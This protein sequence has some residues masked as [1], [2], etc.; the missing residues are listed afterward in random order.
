MG[1]TRNTPKLA[2]ASIGIGLA[3]LFQNMT[4]I[5]F[6]LLN[7]PAVDEG[8]RSEQAREL[9]GAYYSESPASKAEGASHLNYLLYKEI[10]ASLAPQWKQ[11]ALELTQ[12]L[13]AESREQ[14]FDPIFVLAVIQTES[15]FNPNA[16]GTAG[17]IG[18]MQ[19]LPQTGKW[20]AR[21]YRL[22]WAGDRTLHD[23][24]TNIVIGIRYFSYLR[25]HFERTA[26]NYVPAYNMGPKNLKRVN[27][28]VASVDEAGLPAKRIYAIKV[29]KNYERLYQKLNSE[30]ARI[31]LPS[32]PPDAAP[33]FTQLTTDRRAQ[34]EPKFEH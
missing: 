20:I 32:L 3:I 19:I 11:R 21:K 8:A 17:E 24:V 30:Q 22:D 12:T 28:E 31:G 6:S 26:Q 27:R 29:L 10:E 25:S 15:R 16:V 33:I 7:V 4:P 14:N 1:R 2:V 23:P 34:L 5:E 13:I 18:L 9:L